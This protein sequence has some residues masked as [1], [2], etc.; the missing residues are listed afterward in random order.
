VLICV[1]CLFQLSV[2][3]PNQ[4]FN[5]AFVDT[6]AT[7]VPFEVTI[8]HV[9][10]EESVSGNQL[11]SSWSGEIV[12]K[13]ISEKEILLLIASLRLAGRHNHGSIRGPGD[14]ATILVSDDRFFTPDAIKPGSTF[15]VWEAAPGIGQAQCCIDPLEN[16][17]EPK[18]QFQVRFVQFSDG[19]TFGDPS[20]AENDLAV[21]QSIIAGVTRLLQA[22]KQDGEQGFVDELGQQP[23]W[24]KTLVFSRIWQSYQEKGARVALAQANQ[25]LALA[26]KH[27]AS[28]GA[29]RGLRGR[30]GHIDLTDS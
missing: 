18:A 14:G 16:A 25:I 22:Y 27:E 7:R 26:E 10:L 30:G 5:V 21:R 11:E 19:S 2:E 17:Q 4:H 1:F 9:V 15:T 24:S 20:E 3:Q 6:S 13:N 29:R 8:K 23:P 12:L 28:T